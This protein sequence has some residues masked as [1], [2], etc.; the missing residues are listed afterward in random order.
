MRPGTLPA[1]LAV[2]SCRLAA[3]QP[4]LR[5]TPQVVRGV[6]RCRLAVRQ[7][8]PRVEGRK[9]LG[10][11][12][13]RLLELRAGPSDRA[14]SKRV[15]WPHQRRGQPWRLALPVLLRLGRPLARPPEPCQT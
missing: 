6:L 7:P 14:H 10:R 15:A 9:P 11:Q 2:P 5:E 1:A 4:L 13:P 12:G 3:R 8:M